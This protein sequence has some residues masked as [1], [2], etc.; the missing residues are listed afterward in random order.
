M[1]F[2]S[3]EYLFLFLPVVVTLYSIFRTSII[4]KYIVFAA[5]CIFYGWVHP[6]FLI[7]MFGSAFADYFIAQRIYDTKDERKRR[8]WL[9]TSIGFSLTLMSFF[10]YTEWITQDLFSLG[11]ILGLTIIAGPLFVIL[12]PG[13]SFYTFETISYSIDVYR[14][15][16]EPRR[17]LL[18]YL[19]FIVFSRISSRAPF[20]AQKICC[21]CWRRIGRPANDARNEYFPFW[22]P[23]A[24]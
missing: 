19:S 9:W 11:S 16:F 3:F 24:T 13:V 7:P 20:G 6:W 12:P 1:Q 8:W 4:N 22:L 14:G 2:N 21:R 10:K 23:D 5:S 17:K 15:E 18:D